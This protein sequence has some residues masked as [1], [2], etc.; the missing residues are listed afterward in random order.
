MFDSYCLLNE[1]IKKNIIVFQIVI[2]IT[3]ILIL[4]LLY[5]IKIP[6]YLEGKTIPNY[7]SDLSLS[8]IVP[9]DKLNSIKNQRK[10]II[11][12]KK[13]NYQLKEIK[14]EISQENLIIN[15]M[16][17]TYDITN[18]KTDITYKIEID[19]MNFF[20]YL[21]KQKKEGK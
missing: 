21:K 9:K 13:Y 12:E 11:N 7:D 10:I 6:I 15:L 3:S 18:N 14:Q 16:I 8:I 1:K 2:T 5:K 4:L 17:E 19:K 20:D